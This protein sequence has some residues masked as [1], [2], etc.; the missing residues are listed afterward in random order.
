MSRE[1]ENPA[2]NYI[3]KT[4][5]P[6][7]ALL[8]SI[9]SK[10]SEEHVSWQIGADEGKLLQLLITMNNIKTIVEVGALAGYSAI[11]MA[12]A[13]PQDGH[14]YTLGKDP[15]HNALAGEFI[16]ASDV[17]SKITLVKGDAHDT[18]PTLDDKGPFDM[19]FID[20]DKISYPDY[21][22][23]AEKNV[24]KGGL[25]VGDN[26]YLFDTVWLA[27]APKGTAP[28]THK[29]MQ[30]FNKRLSDP[31]KYCSTIIPTAEGM[32]VAVKL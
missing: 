10:L 29:A 11:W 8:T 31:S 3:R 19:V 5:A 7:D 12:R 15:K 6:Q 2:I 14:I 21:L 17:A 1:S 24:R 28:T 23:W 4:F 16:A 20:A 13:L 22:D 25:I 30:E 9:E 32:T 26:T 27:E 18:L